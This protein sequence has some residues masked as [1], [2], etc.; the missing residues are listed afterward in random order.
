MHYLIVGLGN[1]GAS[2]TYTRH[3][4]GF[5]V[6]D[7]LAD[8]QK[9]TFT[10][11]R[12]ASTAHLTYKGRRITL[13]KPTTYMNH[14]GRAVRYWLQALQTDPNHSLVIT[15]DLHLPFGKLRLRPQG[16]HGGHN[17][18]KNIIEVL[19]TS[20]YP[21]LRFGIGDDF[22]KG[23]QS[24]YVLAPFTDEETQQLSPLLQKATD[25]ILA[26]CWRGPTDTM[27]RYNS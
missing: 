10:S 24:D 22:P 3:N 20:H 2:Y 18:L 21:R 17:G 5:R 23:Q 11:N 1:P 27:Q 8:Q 26:F 25:I 14:S 4:I 9:A 16:S 6:L 13:A 19:R 7:T 15:D 12:L